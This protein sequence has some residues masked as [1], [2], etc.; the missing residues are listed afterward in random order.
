M[1][2][3]LAW[4]ILATLSAPAVLAVPA[5][6][7]TQQQSQPAWELDWQAGRREAS[8]DSLQ[9]QVENG[10]ADSAVQLLLAERQL[11]IHRFAAALSTAEQLG[12]D[13]RGVAAQAHYLLGHYEQALLSLDPTDEIQVLML[14]DSHE[15]L[16]HGQQTL[17]ALGQARAV[18]GPNHP[19]LAVAEGRA[20]ARDGKHDEALSAFRRALAMDPFD[21]MALFGLGR[22]LLQLGRRDEA[23]VALARHRELV[24]LMDQRDHALRA[25]DLAPMHADNHALLGDVERKIGRFDQAEAAYVRAAALAEP[26]QLAPVIL[27]HARL[28]SEDRGD[29]TAAVALLDE[30]SRASG[31]IR[32]TVRCGDLL[33]ADGQARAALARFDLALQARPGDAQLTTRRAKALA[34]LQATDE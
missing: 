21:H 34:L 13:G 5:L 11:A 24:P 25:I 20:A 14:V 2:G 33:L 6:S 29:L 9:R 8:V 22:S 12:P 27:R 15:V 1:N 26:G 7:G 30:A 18:L 31:D 10:A 28:L 23:T 4:L 17:D 3:L 32:L 19:A 16:G